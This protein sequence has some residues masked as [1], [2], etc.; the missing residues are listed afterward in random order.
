[1]PIPVFRT[2]K[3]GFHQ[4]K[5]LELSRKEPQESK[6]DISIS[7]SEDGPMAHEVV[8]NFEARARP[9]IEGDLLKKAVQI[10]QQFLE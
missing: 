8:F 9:G 6:Y 3:A 5:G 4:I 2:E 7:V 10:S 1:M